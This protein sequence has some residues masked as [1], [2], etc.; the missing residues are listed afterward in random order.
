M[1]A[2]AGPAGHPADRDGD[3]GPGARVRRR[4]ACGACSPS[5]L[6]AGISGIF[7]PIGC[8][9][10]VGA[11]GA[12]QLFPMYWLGLG[13]RSAFLPDS[14]R[15]AR[16]RRLLADPGDGARARCLGRRRRPRRSRPCC[17]GWLGAS[18]GPRWRPRERPRHN[19]SSEPAVERA[20][21]PMSQTVHN[22]IALLRRTGSHPQ[23]PRGR[24]GRALPDRRLPGSGEN[25]PSLDLALRIAGYFGVPV[26]AV[27]SLRPFPR[28]SDGAGRSA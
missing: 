5:C 1:G 14:R 22:R 24:T 20:G 16:D 13:M 17:A 23:G 21:C 11:A 18:R 6:L 3:R 19:G 27:F 10:G 28:V 25:S 12:A 2:G 26:E 7:Y 8:P 15:G 9:V 4:S